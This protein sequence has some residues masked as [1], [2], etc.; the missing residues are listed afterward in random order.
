MKDK[1]VSLKLPRLMVGQIIDGLRERQKVWLLTAE[2][3]VTGTTE[4]PCIIEEC[5]DA[6]EAKSIAANLQ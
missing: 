1:I 4:E 3:M 5:S 2:F 6:D